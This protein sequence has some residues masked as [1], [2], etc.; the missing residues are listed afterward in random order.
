M[1]TK[2][3]KDTPSKSQTLTKSQRTKARVRRSRTE[4]KSGI[5]VIN[6]SPERRT[7]FAA[8]NPD[9]SFSTDQFAPSKTLQK[10]MS[11][12]SINKVFFYFHTS[13]KCVK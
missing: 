6:E 5:S 12:K 13:P 11:G 10:V 9:I 2:I 3:A 7:K 4:S 1:K 8:A